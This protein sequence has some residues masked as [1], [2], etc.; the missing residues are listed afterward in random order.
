[1]NIGNPH[2]SRPGR[3]WG[4]GRCRGSAQASEEGSHKMDHLRS[5]HWFQNSPVRGH[6]EDL[7]RRECDDIQ[8]G[9]R[10]IQRAHRP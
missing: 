9:S 2:Q 1:M 5:G 7:S 6:L 8:L 4:G 3:R 10:V